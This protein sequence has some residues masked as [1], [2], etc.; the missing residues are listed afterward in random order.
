MNR[1]FSLR[2]NVRLRINIAWDRTLRLLLVFLISIRDY[3]WDY[4]N[5]DPCYFRVSLAEVYYSDHLG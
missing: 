1:I 5:K 2:V 4:K 3:L